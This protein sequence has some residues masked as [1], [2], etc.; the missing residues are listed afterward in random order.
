MVCYI[1]P[2]WTVDLSSFLSSFVSADPWGSPAHF[3]ASLQW[4]ES[5][6]IQTTAV[7][8]EARPWINTKMDGKWMFILP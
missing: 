1:M 6:G 5:G 3:T 8:Q 7:D 4:A 2:L